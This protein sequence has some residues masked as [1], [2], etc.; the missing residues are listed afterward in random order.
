MKVL[1]VK[2]G[3]MGDVV[4]ALSMLEAL[5]Q[6]DPSS[7]VTWVCG[8]TVEP[9]LKSTGKVDE[10]IA[11][12]EAM[13]LKG[14]IFQRLGVLLP[15]WGRLVGRRFDLIVTGHSDPRYRLLGALSLG[16]IRRSFGR[17]QGRVW[18]VPGRYHGHEYA[19]LITGEDG[20]EAFKAK[21]FRLVLPLRP[22]LQKELPP[23]RKALVALAPGGSRNVLRDDALRRWPVENYRRLAEMLLK[24]GFSV[25]L[26]GSTSDD[27]VRDAFRGM[28]MADWIG[29]TDL[30]DLTA[31]YALCRLVVT[32]DSGPLHLAAL[33]GA[34][35]LALLGPTNPFEKVPAGSRTRVLWGGEDLACRPCYDG[36]NYADCAHNACLR[37]VTVERVYEEAVRLLNKAPEG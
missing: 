2:I 28:D 16:K 20:P 10:T 37:N 5:F 32:H 9:L 27:W 24:E 35:C 34:P 36:K 13:L 30:L 17:I 1:V 7:H 21:A 33:S 25:V 18:P 26:T 22:E 3:A 15:L 23:S 14:N 4:M 6:K 12:D 29:K 31:L 19:R 11:L 8:R